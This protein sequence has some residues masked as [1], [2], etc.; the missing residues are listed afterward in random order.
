VILTV[1]SFYLVQLVPLFK[2]ERYDLLIARV[3]LLI[4]LQVAF[5]IIQWIGWYEW[6]LESTSSPIQST[7]V[8]MYCITVLHW[9]HVIAGFVYTCWMWK[10]V[11]KAM[12]DSV[13]ELVWGRNPFTQLKWEL[14]VLYWHFMDVLWISIFMI[15][16]F[17]S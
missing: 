13:Q 11:K 6:I 17:L 7:G 4:V 8:L 3:R 16:F 12:K 9:L 5:S 10:E 14:L 15:F 2:Q 1:Q